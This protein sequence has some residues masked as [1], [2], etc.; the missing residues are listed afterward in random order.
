[1]W[2]MCS[3][4]YRDKVNNPNYYKTLL[5]NK[6]NYPDYSEYT[7]DKV[8]ITTKLNQDLKRTFPKNEKFN[9]KENLKILKNVLIAYSRRNTAIGYV[10]GFNFI[11]G[12]IIQIVN[13][14]VK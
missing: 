12:R 13:D 9:T 10:Q 5:K 4:A 2:L 6:N 11:A 3:G 7:I 14:E 1:M 8:I